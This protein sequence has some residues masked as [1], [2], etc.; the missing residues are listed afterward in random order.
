MALEKSHPVERND[1][2]FPFF[3]FFPFPIEDNA[4]MKWFKKMWAFPP[5]KQIRIENGTQT[6]LARC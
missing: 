1:V 4:T 6:L 5:G 3:P 2:F